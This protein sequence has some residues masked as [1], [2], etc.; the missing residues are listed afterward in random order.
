[1]GAIIAKILVMQ[2]SRSLVPSSAAP[3]DLDIT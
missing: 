2:E 3:L 1:M